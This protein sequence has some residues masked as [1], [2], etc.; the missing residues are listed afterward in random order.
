M[1]SW[2]SPSPEASAGPDPAL[3]AR[4]FVEASRRA[5]IVEL[6]NA[7]RGAGE[8]ARATA[9]EL[10]E[11]LE[12]EVAFVV[13]TRPEVGERETLA[14]VGLTAAQ[15]GTVP[16][17]PL[18]R[19]ALATT[20]AELHAGEDLLGLGVRHLA[21][22]P[23][24]VTDGRQVLV[25]VGRL[26]DEPFDEAETALL[27]AVTASA[28]HALE[29][30]WLAAER[31]RQT[32]R[33]AALAGAARALS[34]SLVADEVLR[35][36]AGE[37]LRAFAADAVAVHAVGAGGELELVAGSGAEPPGAWAYAPGPFGLATRVAGEGV[38]RTATRLPPGAGELRAAVA[39]PVR[40]QSDVEAV[41]LAG[42]RADRRL[43]D[44]DVELLAALADLAGM[45]YRNAV[46]HAAARRAAA[47]DSLTGCLNHGAFQDRL[48]D[49][50]AR[51]ERTEGPLALA[52]LDLN[53]FKTVNDTLGHL[54][55]DAL[56][57]G[58]ADALR[59]AVRS[60]D[61]VARYG[62]D[63]FAL[64][65]PATDEAAARRVVERARRAIAE[66]P[67]PDGLVASAGTG[68]AH[69]R[70]GDDA[71]RLIARADRAL[72]QSKRARR[73][74]PPP[75]GTPRPAAQREDQRLRRL[76]TAGALG[77][78][79][80]RLLDERVIAE[81]AVVELGAALGYERCVLVR[82]EPDGEPVVVAAATERGTGAGTPLDEVPEVV[83]RALADGRTVLDRRELAVTVDAGGERWGALGLRAGAGAPFGEDDAQLVQHLAEHLG[84]ALRTAR[85][86]ANLDRTYLGTAA[87]LAA[88]LEAKDSYTADHA[89]SIA[90]LAVAVGAELGLDEDGLRDL[91]YGAIFHDIGKIA[92]PDAILNK[93]GP[94][95]D[96]ELA[97]VRRHPEVGEQ[98]LEPVPFLAGVRRIV[99]HDH[100]R[101]DGAGYPDG[102]RGDA[103]PLGAR[104]VLVVDAYHAMRSDRPYRRALGASAA[105][106][107]LLRHAG[108]QFDP[109]V[110][111]ALLGV[112]ER[113]P[114]A[115]P[116]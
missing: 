107:E 91:R 27:E 50:L 95:D 94:L 62:G 32:A 4:R 29:R 39:A 82:L 81:T 41:V 49:E 7:A 19:A 75:A 114:E 10:C 56:L 71:E 23:W 13:A 31:D 68:L 93:P 43:D 6:L 20:R 79:L 66:V 48:R 60:Y 57:R 86:Y 25:A 61:G 106:A 84:A 45:A 40:P 33:Q 51:A 115:E 99:R 72:L 28:G 78:R 104:V 74:E 54:A 42:F 108:T 47:V 38:A 70:P 16:A 87:A 26:F 102:L 109:Q 89:R 11:A 12:A 8:I 53:D 113:A 116:V 37:V 88:A 30:V 73:R 14:S 112:L 101:W 1:R 77:T 96:T 22:A 105:R 3:A 58:V 97:V 2:W 18:S 100:E 85:L 17:D 35:T 15:A 98:I 92:I 69:R 59:R 90:D 111:D 5:E 44:D 110:V 80:S 64:L 83:L 76:A 9:D 55:G 21:L 46:D 34:A 36:L 65:L 103:I 67:L 24:R 52:L 63:E